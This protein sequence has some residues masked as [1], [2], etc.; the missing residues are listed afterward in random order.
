MSV[1]EMKIEAIRKI[2]EL[3]DEKLL[4]DILVQLEKVPDSET[5]LL[6]QHYGSIRDEYFTVLEKLAK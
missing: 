2:T 5:Y 6:A 4:K 3:E 1:D